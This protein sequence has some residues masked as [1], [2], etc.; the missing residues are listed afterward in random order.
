MTYVRTTFPSTAVAVGAALC[1]TGA[2]VAIIAAVH[3]NHWQ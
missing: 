1:A 3:R 2:V